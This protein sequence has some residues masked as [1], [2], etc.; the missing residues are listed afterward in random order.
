MR[1]RARRRAGCERWCGIRAG[2]ELEIPTGDVVLDIFIVI[3]DGLDAEKDGAEDEGGDEE[4]GEHF[5][6][7]PACEAQTAMPWSG[8]CHED[9]SVMAPQEILMVLLASLKNVGIG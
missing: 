5:F 2:L 1:S 6:F 7:L 3:L 8:C 4:P 9:D